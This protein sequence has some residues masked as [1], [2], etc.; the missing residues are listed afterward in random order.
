VGR[1]WR[2]APR[3][4]ISITY[5]EA[6]SAASSFAELSVL[7][8]QVFLDLARDQGGG[9]RRGVIGKKVLKANLRGRILSWSNWELF[10][11]FFPSFHFQSDSPDD[12]SGWHPAH[13]WGE[14]ARPPTAAETCRRLCMCAAAQLGDIHRNPS[15]LVA[16][17]Q[18]GRRD[19]T[20]DGLLSLSKSRS[21]TL[22]KIR[23]FADLAHRFPKCFPV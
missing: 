23:N 7:P 3:L 17:E 13:R 15:R 5:A 14:E 21:A 18:L 22:W 12:G 16:S 11:G 10:T 2:D 6:A 20:T 19:A 8:P 9:K 4:G 1:L